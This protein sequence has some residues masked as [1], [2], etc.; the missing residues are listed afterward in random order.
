MATRKRKATKKG[1]ARKKSSKACLEELGRRRH[2]QLAK[3]RG[4]RAKAITRA[5]AVKIGRGRRKAINKYNKKK[6]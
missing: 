2:R 5:K 3:S 6:R 1:C 4:K